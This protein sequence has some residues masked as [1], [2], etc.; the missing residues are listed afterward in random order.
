MEKTTFSVSDKM[1]QAIDYLIADRKEILRGRIHEWV[2][3][4][5]SRETFDP[6]VL[7]FD[8]YKFAVKL[9]QKLLDEDFPF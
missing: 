8:R 6:M 4:G 7:A 9:K 3:A 5:G 1:Q 2:D